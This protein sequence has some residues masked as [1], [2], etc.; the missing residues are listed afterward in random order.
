MIFPPGEYSIYIVGD[1]WV[2][3]Q[4]LIALSHGKTNRGNIKTGF[5]N[6]ADTL[7]NAQSGPLADQQGHTADDLR[8][9]YRQGEAQARQVSQK[10]SVKEIAYGTAYDSMASLQHD[11]TNVAKEGN[12]RIKEIQD[13]KEPVAAKVP[14]IV[15]AI[16]QYR[17]LANVVAAKYSGNVFDAM[18]RILDTE[19]SGQSARQFAQSH[20]VDVGNMFRQPD[21][22]ASLTQEVTG[23]LNGVPLPALASGG[24][25]PP[26][27]QTPGEAPPP[28]HPVAPAA[29]G[30]GGGLPAGVQAGGGT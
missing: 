25:L 3:D 28:P 21:D 11:L 14:Q 1:Q 9:T 5:S 27:V 17:A 8:N 19:G 16:H 18:Q 6:F 20:G 12:E 22:E 2:D 24:G 29:F 15:A 10:N 7:C 23:K 4:D 26:G 30:S 13:S